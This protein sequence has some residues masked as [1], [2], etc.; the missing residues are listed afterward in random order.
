MD[1]FPKGV[2]RRDF[3][4]NHTTTYQEST[5]ATHFHEEIEIYIPVEGC[6][7]CLIDN[8]L[9]N[10]K[11]FDI[12]IFKPNQIH[13]II[14]DEDKKVER[15]LIIFKSHFLQELM[16]SDE[17]SQFHYLLSNYKRIVFSPEESDIKKLRSLIDDFFVNIQTEYF[18]YS[19]SKIRT[20]EIIIFILTLFQ[21]N[22][23]FTYRSNMPQNSLMTPILN[24]IEENYTVVSLDMLA[25]HFNLTK[26]Y[27]CRLF[28]K[29]TS[30]TV[31]EYILSKKITHAKKF[32]SGG[33]NVT[34]TSELCGFNNITNF[35]RVLKKYANISPKQYQLK[36]K[37]NKA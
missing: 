34:E 10:I 15:Y 12:I 16:S 23:K 27:L 29:N 7:G 25:S 8:E 26:N 1:N 35:V 18:N 32:L 19:L 5:Y 11:P 6:H 37:N 21:K 14:R 13:R 2:E 30:M 17:F 33:K 28:K 3:L 22:K 20:A 24:Y 36:F 4:I 9:F 31:N